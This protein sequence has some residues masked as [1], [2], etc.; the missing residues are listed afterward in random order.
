MLDKSVQYA[1][2]D[3]YGDLCTTQSKISGS[4][5]GIYNDALYCLPDVICHLH[6]E[7]PI[8]EHH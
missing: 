3:I 5:G 2:M 8:H 1:K 7:R 6:T 4:T